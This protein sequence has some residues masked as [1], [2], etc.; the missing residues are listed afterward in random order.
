MAIDPKSITWDEPAVAPSIDP[1]GIVWDEPV[2]PA[3]AQTQQEAAPAQSQGMG[4]PDAL[5]TAYNSLIGSFVQPAANVQAGAVRGAGSI[6]S[7]LLAPYD[8]AKDA[9]A[10]KGL[11]L[12]SN[13]AR[14]EGIDQ[15]LAALGADPAST[16]YAGGKLVG[17]IAGT[18]GI[19]P[20][21][22]IGA[23]GMGASPAVVSA[24][25]TGGLNIGG[26][27]GLPGF[28]LRA[29]SGAT[30]GGASAGL[31][32]PEDAKLGAAIG[33][34]FPVTAKLIGAGM[35]GLGSSLRGQV[36]P[37]VSALADRAK[38]LGVNIPADRITNSKPLN[39][40][41][42]SLEYMPF[43]GRAAT[44][45]QMTS[46]LNRALS[47]T[48]GQDSDNV[49]MALRKASDELGGKF[50]E[51]LKNNRVTVDQ[52]FADALSEQAARASRE[53]GS[54][55]QRII[56]NQI[57]DILAKAAD[58]NIDGQAA[59]NI[60]RTLD[61][62]GKR[63][64]PEAFYALDLKRSLMD[65]LDRSLGPE[66]SAAFAKTREQYGNMLRLEKIAKNGAEGDISIA[67]LANMKNVNS[68]DLQELADIAAQFMT[69]RENP[70]G[71]LQRLI[72]GS[73]GLGVG[74]GMA[75]IPAG[76][77]IMA[78]G[79]AANSALNSGLLR[80]MVTRP[81]PLL[82]AGTVNTGLLGASK[83]APVLSAQ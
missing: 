49:T 52:Q 2:A 55:G 45:E 3:K 34:A 46:Q 18:S 64:S 39:A 76:I 36:S 19:G 43:S 37:E 31:I 40:L 23:K 21:L 53:L 83:V 20:A 50:D 16:S 80:S 60:K 68:P 5:K 59:Y 77:G 70:H 26:L 4:V 17:E 47:R 69:T 44:Q 32:N 27:K 75:G 35:R 48:F 58:G 30:V 15:G 71:A 10:G 42:A 73:T 66:A 33:G 9:M 12:E 8:M 1:T 7:T 63:N 61:R 56:Q 82:P 79:R 22:A 6:G 41:A 65:A 57:D 67:R 29:A 11:S 78:G 13:R 81:S 54:D 25:E 24:L 72:I 62:I 28:G 51:V 38:E 74:A 14:R